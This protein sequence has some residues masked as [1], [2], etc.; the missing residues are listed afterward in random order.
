MMTQERTTSHPDPKLATSPWRPRHFRFPFFRAFRK[1]AREELVGKQERMRGLPGAA[2]RYLKPIHFGCPTRQA[3][4]RS[5]RSE[6]VLGVSAC[7]AHVG[8]P[9]AAV[10]PLFCGS[11]RDLLHVFRAELTF[12]PS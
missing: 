11:H 6:N 3:Q 7:S 1:E 10:G 2:R 4:S 5:H 12:R 8:H 9:V